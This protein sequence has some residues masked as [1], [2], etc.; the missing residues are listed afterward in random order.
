MEKCEIIATCA[1]APLTY[2]GFFPSKG[3]LICKKIHLFESQNR[4]EMKIKRN[5]YIGTKDG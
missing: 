1:V 2:L 5:R 3:K 4:R